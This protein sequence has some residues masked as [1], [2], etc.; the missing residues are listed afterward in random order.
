MKREASSHKSCSVFAKA[1]ITRNALGKGLPLI[2]SQISQLSHWQEIKVTPYQLSRA[3]NA[4]TS[5]IQTS[6]SCC[7]VPLATSMARRFA[8]HFPEV[9]GTLSF[10]ISSLSESTPSHETTLTDVPE[11][12]TLLPDSFSFLRIL[13]KARQERTLL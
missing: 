11:K 5:V 3:I 8:L 12:N 10:P 9:P 6:P 1:P 7:S 13:P 4:R 2:L